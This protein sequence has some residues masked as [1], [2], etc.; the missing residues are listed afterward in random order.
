MARYLTAKE[1]KSANKRPTATAL[2]RGMR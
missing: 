1:I 2:N